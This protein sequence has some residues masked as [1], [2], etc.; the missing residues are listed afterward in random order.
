MSFE[1]VFRLFIIEI[2]RLVIKFN[3]GLT[4]STV[5]IKH[6]QIF[7]QRKILREQRFFYFLDCCTVGR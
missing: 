3:A 6:E 5:I 7:Q 2:S 4:I 1:C